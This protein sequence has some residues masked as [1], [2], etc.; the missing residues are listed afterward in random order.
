MPVRKAS[1]ALI[2]AL[3]SAILY[4]SLHFVTN[5]IYYVIKQPYMDEIFHVPQAQRYCQGNFTHY[6]PKI[7]TPP[8]LYIISYIR[9]WFRDVV[10][11][12]QSELTCDTIDLRRTN[13][14]IA[15]SNYVILVLIFLTS[16]NTVDLSR[17]VGFRQRIFHTLEQSSR[18]DL[19]RVLLSSIAVTLLP[20]LFFFN[21]L[22]YTDAGS[23]L[24]TLLAYLF[25][26]NDH[27]LLASLLGIAS[28]LFRQT[29]I[30]WLF[31]TAF[32]VVLRTF[33]EHNQSVSNRSNEESQD[34]IGDRHL[35]DN[36]DLLRETALKL[37]KRC[38]PYATVG[39]LFL[40]FIVIN[41]GVVLGD[42]E[43]HQPRQHWAQILYFLA[44]CAFF[45]SSWMFQLRIIRRFLYFLVRN[46]N[47]A[48]LASSLIICIISFGRYAHPYL[49]ADNRHIT[50]YIWRRILG[51]HN[52]CIPYL[53]TPIYLFSFLGIWHHLRRNGGKRAL[54]YLIC[55]LMVT[56]PNGL[57][58]LR[59]FIIPYVIL[60]FNTESSIAGLIYEIG[61][62]LAIDIGMYYLFSFKTFY[63]TDSQEV[64]RIMW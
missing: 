15:V 25:S 10:M 23:L 7:T 4:L 35:R 56:V 36:S 30:V 54:L 38:T 11:F 13:H 31:H 51:R 9:I 8:G 46:P 61:Q 17:K 28:I 53:L 21:S 5:S 48:L 22:Y 18:S 12:R 2:V 29:N 52:S 64:Q 41:G 20:P 32:L 60:R 55:T 47:T 24:F 14:I 62:N 6:D 1:F 39:I 45:G 3:F 26:I 63:W 40:I 37:V 49:L 59:Y 43:A 27:H 58:E 50:F 34:N 44:F 16:S 57:L 33:D 42:K 19:A